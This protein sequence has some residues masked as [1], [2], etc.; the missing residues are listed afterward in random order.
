[1]S[2]FGNLGITHFQLN[3]YKPFFFI[4]EYTHKHTMARTEIQFL[5]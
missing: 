3:I 1:M 2:T 4:Y 5:I